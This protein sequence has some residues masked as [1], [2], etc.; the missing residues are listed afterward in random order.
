VE[1]PSERGCEVIHFLS[2]M[3]NNMRG[4]VGEWVYLDH[5]GN[6]IYIVY[7]KYISES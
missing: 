3:F 1:I 5:M 7:I 2:C 6:F 4:R